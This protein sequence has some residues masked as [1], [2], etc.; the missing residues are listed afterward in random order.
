MNID[1]LKR[2]VY[3]LKKNVHP[4]SRLLIKSAILG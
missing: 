3:N 1:E 2:D 4:N